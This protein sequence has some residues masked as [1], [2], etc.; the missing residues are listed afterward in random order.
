MTSSSERSNDMSRSLTLL[1]ILSIGGVE[2]NEFAY[3]TLS[4]PNYHLQE[5]LDSLS[6]VAGNE[7]PKKFVLYTPGKT[8]RRDDLKQPF[9]WLQAGLI[10]DRAR[11]LE[12][13][14]SDLSTRGAVGC[15]S[16]LN[17]TTPVILNW[18]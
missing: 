18:G 14:E 2:P 5:C 17:R 9:K 13:H 7:V 16:A 6:R 12:I 10:A 4:V 8:R 15:I 1:P 3:T 11:S